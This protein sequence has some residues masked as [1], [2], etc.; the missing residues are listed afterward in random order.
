M[1]FFALLQVKDLA[2]LLMLL[3]SSEGVLKAFV[4]LKKQ[5]ILYLEVM[6]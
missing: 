1:I 3:F 2:L 4:F 6:Q 5:L